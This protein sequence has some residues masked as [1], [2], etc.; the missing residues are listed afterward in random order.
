MYSSSQSRT[1]R[2][3]TLIELLVV[4]AII[5]IL[6][7]VVMTSLASARLKAK[8]AAIVSSLRQFTKLLELN[9]LETK[10]YGNLQRNLWNDCTFTGS[11]AAEAADICNQVIALSAAS[12][13]RFYT[14]SSGGAAAYPNT[15]VVMA[16]LPGKGTYVCMSDG[17]YSDTQGSAGT[18]YWLEPGCY[19]NP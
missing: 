9:H 18:T 8:D 3:F 17:K 5:G 4:V 2:G 6:S 16:R 19:Q 15:Y 7:S 10:T 13:N 12:G 1:S 11:F 14:G